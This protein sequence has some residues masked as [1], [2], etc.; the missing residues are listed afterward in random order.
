MQR[1]RKKTLR[2]QGRTLRAGA[3]AINI[4]DECEQ[5]ARASGAGPMQPRRWL[6]APRRLGQ[7]P[8]PAVMHLR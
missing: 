2:A 4:Y 5:Q 6:F 3:E 8:G 7:L 1:S